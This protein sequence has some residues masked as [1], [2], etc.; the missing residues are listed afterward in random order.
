MRIT[1]TLAAGAALA[2]AAACGQQRTA[3]GPA[4]AA[5]REFEYIATNASR[6]TCTMAYGARGDTTAVAIG[7]VPAGG[8]VSF[9]VRQ[10]RG[11]EMVLHSTCGEETN[12]YDLRPRRRM[13]AVGN[14]PPPSRIQ[15]QE[16]TRCGANSRYTSATPEC[17]RPT[18]DGGNG[19]PSTRARGDGGGG[20]DTPNP[21]VS[22]S[23]DP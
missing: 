14:T 6:T 7:E 8:I 12:T 22:P 3:A 19:G 17:G 5:E 23:K 11:A 2:V 16:R 20:G 15:I 13:V 4:P 1:R 10:E 21:P 18:S 9:T